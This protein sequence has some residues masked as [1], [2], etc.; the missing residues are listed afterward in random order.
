M[1][2]IVNKTAVFA[3][4]I[5]LL[6]MVLAGCSDGKVQ[7]G[8]EDKVLEY[9]SAPGN[10]SFPE[11]ALDL[12][13]LGDLELKSI[14]TT[15][16]GPESIQLTATKQTDFGSAFNGAIIKSFSQ[17]VRIKSVIGAYGSD[18]NTYIGAYVLDSSEIKAPKD[19]IGKKVGVNTL[20]AHL[21]FVLKDY[22]RKGGLTEKEI[23]Q[24]TLVTIPSANAEQILRSKQIDSVLLGGIARDL[25]LDRGGIVEIF[26]DIEVFNSEFTAGDYFFTDEYIKNNP[27]TVKQFVEGVAK[28]IEWART[29]PREDVIKRLET[30]VEKRDGKDKIGN[31]KFWKSTG[32]AQTGGVITPD[33]Y[34]VWIDWLVA[35]GDLKEGQLKAENLYTNEFNSYYKP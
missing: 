14:G 16:G 9:N 26:K 23:E 24:V 11:L 32:I 28:A 2:K 6:G 1:N 5:G 4:V 30:I 8:E 22:L 18:K 19:F 13:Y 15:T 31:L 33:E 21:E 17:N 25:A 12:G 27:S 20:G 29:T 7:A 34:Q 35:N 10:V 3:I